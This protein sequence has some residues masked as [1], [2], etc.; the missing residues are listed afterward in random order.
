MK[1]YNYILLGL[2]LPLTSCGT[3]KEREKGEARDTHESLI[4]VSQEQYRALNM[5]VGELKKTNL[6]QL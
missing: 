3:N 4:E 6:T 5:E 1:R 2:L